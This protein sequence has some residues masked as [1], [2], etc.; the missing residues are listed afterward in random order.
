MYAGL[1]KPTCILPAHLLTPP[2]VFALLPLM[3]LFIP[4]DDEGF[5]F[6]GWRDRDAL[7]A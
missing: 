3:P 4:G 2:S 7:W 6:R 5:N 1:T